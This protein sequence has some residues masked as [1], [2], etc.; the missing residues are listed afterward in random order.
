MRFSRLLPDG[1]RLD[2]CVIFV[3]EVELRQLPLEKVVSRVTFG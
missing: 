1:W 2:L 3:L